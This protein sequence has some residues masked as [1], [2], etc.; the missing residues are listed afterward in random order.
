[1]AGKSPT[2]EARVA[3]DISKML[4]EF[5][6][7][8]ISRKGPSRPILERSIA[9]LIKIHVQAERQ[10]CLHYV[11][12]CSRLAMTRIADQVPPS[13]GLAF[14]EAFALLVRSWNK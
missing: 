12:L 11:E 8:K 1:M 5:I 6:G 9:E 13:A 3:R 2:P 14:D 7:Q 10:R 4:D